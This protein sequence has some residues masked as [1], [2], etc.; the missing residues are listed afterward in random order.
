MPEW[1]KDPI[2]DRWVVI[3]TERGKR[4]TDF[5]LPPEEKKGG[6]CPLCQGHEWQTPPEVLSFREQDSPRNKPGWWVRVV[7]NKFPALRIEGRAGER[8]LGLQR[9]MDGVGAHEVVVETT[10]HNRPLEEQNEHQIREVI[11]AWRDRTLDLR[12]DKRFRYIQIFK[13]HG[14]PA[15]A[16]L[17][18]PHSQIMSLPMVPGVIREKLQRLAGHARATGQCLVCGMIS[19][20]L[21]EQNR[22]VDANDSFLA[23]AP[24]ASRVPFE[25]WIIPREHQPDFGQIR[26][27][28]VAGLASLTRAVIGKIELA[29]GSAPYNLMI[30]TSPV[31]GD[32]EDQKHFHWHLEILP[33]L[34]TAAG[35]ELGTGFYINPT[36]PEMAAHDLRE[37]AV[38]FDGR[39]ASKNEEVGKY[40]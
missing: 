36:P 16:S 8:C 6:E 25:T 35:F 20:E 29:L 30:N 14:G 26:E 13:N 39:Q 5:K 17:D 24:F 7:P 27:D 32:Q 21:Q 28:Q 37:T 9:V 40:V 2:L 33:R 18:H 38:V 10:D 31:N 4:P 19:Q 34:T 15:G 12:R 22:V 11:R 3:A 23:L 1:R